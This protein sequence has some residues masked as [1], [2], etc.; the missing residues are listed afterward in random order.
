MK[1]LITGA[2]SGIGKDM[3][4]YLSSLGHEVIMVSSNKEKLLECQKEVDNSKLFVADLTKEKEVNKLIDYIY[5]E[6]PEIV[7]NDAGF[8]AFGYYNEVSLEKEMNMIGV[9]IIALHKITKACLS[10]MDEGSYILNVASIAGLMPGGA[11][12]NTYYASK[13]YV[14]SY[15][16]GLYEELK[17]QNK[18][19]NISVLCPGPVDTNFNKVAG[20]HFSIASLSSEYVSKYAIDKMFKK[21]LLIIPGTSVKLGYYF[22]RFIPI[23]VILDVIFK[24]QHKKINLNK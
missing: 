15:S 19:I 17:K 18:K 24:V 8:G 22:Q 3:S 14:R 13:S 11:L 21:K 20:G 1:C 4:K 9:N 7:I 6:K 16:L 23:K 5:K 10:Y 12:L 2:S